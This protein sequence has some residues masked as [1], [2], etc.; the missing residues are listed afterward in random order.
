MFA[1]PQALWIDGV[2]TS[3]PR[4]PGGP[5]SGTFCNNDRT[6]KFSVSHSYGKRIRRAVRLD[7]N[8]F[9]ADPL[10]SAQN[11][12]R[13]GS[14]YMVVDAPVQGFSVA[15]LQSKVVTLNTWISGSS[16]AN[17]PKFLGGES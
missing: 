14:V 2:S 9:A 1:D 16:Y 3:T 5:N 10:T 6:L 13:S 8:K 7:F 12:F 15:D 17:V 4:I 11:V